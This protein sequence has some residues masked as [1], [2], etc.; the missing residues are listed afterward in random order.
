VTTTREHEARL[1]EIEARL[2]ELGFEIDFDLGAIPGEGHLLTRISDGELVDGLSANIPE[3]ALELAREWSDLLDESGERAQS[4]RE[5][6]DEELEEER[7][8]GR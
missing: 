8:R 5:G 3:E 7:G 1:T 6:S 4:E 2:Q